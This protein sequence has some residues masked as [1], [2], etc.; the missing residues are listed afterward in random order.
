MAQN[1]M[2]STAAP[3]GLAPISAAAYGS[4][5]EHLRTDV[6]SLLSDEA[7]ALV[8]GPMLDLRRAAAK[9]DAA[10]LTMRILDSAIKRAV[11]GL[12]DYEVRRAGLAPPPRVDIDTTQW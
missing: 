5:V 11:R 1:A 6:L 4:S 10:P 7:K 12:Y 2:T 8:I 9:G 3:R